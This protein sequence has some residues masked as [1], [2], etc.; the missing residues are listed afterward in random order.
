MEQINSKSYKRIKRIGDLLGLFSSVISVFLII[1]WILRLFGICSKVVVSSSME[2]DIKVGSLVVIVPVKPEKL[3]VGDD[4]TYKFQDSYCV[5]HRVVS[6][7]RNRRFVVTKGVANEQSDGA[8]PFKDILGKVTL[9][10]PRVGYAA[11]FLSSIPG[12]LCT[13][14]VLVIMCGLSVF[15]DRTA[16]KMLNKNNFINN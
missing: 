10:I 8:V 11:E 4:I 2:P 5:T 3:S 1:A 6:I 13:I 14:T 16:K 15:L 9:V 12:K 7:D